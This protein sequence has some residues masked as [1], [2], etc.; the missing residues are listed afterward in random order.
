MF[1]YRKMLEMHFDGFSQ[2]T[3]ASSTGHARLNISNI[4][5]R[6]KEKGLTT[7]EDEMNNEWL[8]Q[9]LFPERETLEKGYYPTDWDYIHKELMKKN[10]T[11]TLL[12]KEY[13]Y[14][15]R[16]SGKIPYSYRS[17]CVKYQKYASK[18]KFTMPIKRKPGEIIEVDWAGNTLSVIDGDTGELIKAY[19]FIATYHI[20][21]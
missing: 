15:A 17:F 7:L 10:V 6:A 18:F 16:N 3:I 20:V 5:Q 9:Y 19:V 4:I 2:R 13:E 21:S 12:H 8:S 1:Q 14:E 11:L